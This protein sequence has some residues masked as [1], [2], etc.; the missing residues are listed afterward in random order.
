VKGIKVRGANIA[1][2]TAIA[3][4]NLKVGQNIKFDTNATQ[5]GKGHAAIYT[6]QN[7]AGI[8]VWDQWVISPGVYHPVSQ[9]TIRFKGG[10]PNTHGNSDDGD[11]FYV[12][13]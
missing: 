10:V 7:S 6:S 13:N 11:Q 8:Q 9:R 4:F 1:A 12:I 3:T 5:P 2:G